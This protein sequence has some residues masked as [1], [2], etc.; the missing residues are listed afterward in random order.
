M[1][2]NSSSDPVDDL[3]TELVVQAEWDYPLP[4]EVARRWARRVLTVHP[5]LLPLY[6]DAVRSPLAV[7][8]LVLQSGALVTGATACLLEKDGLPGPIILQRTVPVQPEDT[9]ET[10][11]RRVTEEAGRLL[12]PK[13]LAM[14]CSGRLCIH[15]R[16]TKLLPVLDGPNPNE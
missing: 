14:F 4:P 10:L 12:L 13:A 11:L 16:Q 7:Q 2:N 6:D 9:P 5:A 3:D 8:E 1:W 15:G